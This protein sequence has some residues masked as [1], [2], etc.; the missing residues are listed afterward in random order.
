M[1]KGKPFVKWAGGKR[2]I[3]DKLKKYVPDTLYISSSIGKITKY[4]MEEG[5]YTIPFIRSIASFFCS[6][7]T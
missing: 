5:I 6:G 3:I 4:K 1:I 2:Q 7:I